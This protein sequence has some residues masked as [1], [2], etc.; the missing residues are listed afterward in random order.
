MNVIYHFIYRVFAQV[1][2]VRVLSEDY[3]G[4]SFCGVSFET[5]FLGGKWVLSFD[6]LGI[7]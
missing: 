5:N 1:S 7:S 2:Q 4:K 3:V 6:M